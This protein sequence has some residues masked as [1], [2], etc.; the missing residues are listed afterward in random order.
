MNKN[1]GKELIE[2]AIEFKT[3][4][5]KYF[6]KIFNKVYIL[7]NWQKI[8]LLLTLIACIAGLSYSLYY[9][10]TKYITLFLAGL[11]LLIAWPLIK[12]KKK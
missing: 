7:K 8:L 4:K 10:I 12:R 9:F 3:N 5:A 1:I 2:E 6:L 11:I